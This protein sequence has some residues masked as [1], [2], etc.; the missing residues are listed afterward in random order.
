MCPRPLDFAVA[1]SD[2]HGTNLSPIALTS[3]LGRVSGP[4]TSNHLGGA[5]QWRPRRGLALRLFVGPDT[6]AR[7]ESDPSIGI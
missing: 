1:V 2:Y 7:P 4:P 3:G 5:W 6:T